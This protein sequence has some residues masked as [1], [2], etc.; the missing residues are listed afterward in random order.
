MLVLQLKYPTNKEH[1][2]LER[3]PF[4]TEMWEVEFRVVPPQTPRGADGLFNGCPAPTNCWV[5]VTGN[6]IAIE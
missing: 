5:P 6:W 4:A 3:I 2:V 1:S